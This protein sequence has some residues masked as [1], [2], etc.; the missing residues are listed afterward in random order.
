MATPYDLFDCEYA[1]YMLEA[2]RLRYPEYC[3]E[4]PAS[5]LDTPKER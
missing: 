4:L 3:R 2:V 1:V 5:L